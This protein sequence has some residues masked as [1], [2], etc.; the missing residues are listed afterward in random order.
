MWSLLRQR[1][2]SLVL[3]A[4]VVS[5]SGDIVLYVALPFYVY[6]LTGSALATGAM[7][8][9][10]TIPPLLLGSLAGVFVD[11]WDRK[12]TMIVADVARGAVLLLLLFVAS[13]E[14]L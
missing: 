3:V 6:Q 13:V 12:R 5:N 8:V 1:N 14:M 7:F 11:R 4:R 2:F 10:E 9:A